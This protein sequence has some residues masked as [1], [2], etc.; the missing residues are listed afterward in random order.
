MM[1]GTYC[2]ARQVLSRQ[3]RDWNESSTSDSRREQIQQ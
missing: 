2:C 1:A 3:A